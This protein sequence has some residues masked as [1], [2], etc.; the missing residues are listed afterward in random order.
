MQDAELKQNAQQGS[1][2]YQA[3]SRQHI[4]QLMVQAKDVMHRYFGY[5][6]FRSYQ[7][8]LIQKVFEGRD[9]LGVMPT[10]AGKSLVYQIP[11]AVLGGLSLVVS[12]LI[13]LMKDQVDAL[14]QAGLAAAYLN[15]SLSPAERTQVYEGA[16]RGDFHILYV[17]PERLEDPQFLDVCSRIDIPLLAVDEAHCV[18]QWGN[19]FRPS[20]R[21]IASFIGQLPKRP[22]ICALTATATAEV[23][24]DISQALGLYAPFVCVAGFDRENLYFAVERPEPSRKNACLL[25]HV[26]NRTMQSGIVYCST[27]AA[28]EE[29]S[30]LLQERGIKAAGYHAGMDTQ[31]RQKNQD[32]FIN[33]RIAIMVATNAFG[34]GI[35]KSNVN[36]VIHYNM[37]RD[38]E[39]YY[40]EAGRAGRDGSPADCILIYNKKDVQTANY[41]VDR[42]LEERREQ[43]MDELLADRLY[44]LDLDRVRKMTA[45]C[46]TS[47]CL[48]SFLL[49]YFG[50]NETPFRCEHCSTCEAAYE[51]VDATLEAQKIISCVL[52][53]DQRG[54]SV[55]RTMIVDI[56]RGSQAQKLLD[57]NFDTLSTYGI[58]KGSPKDLMHKLMDALVSEGILSIST[59]KYPIVSC[60]SKGLEFLNKREKFTF[61][62]AK[63]SSALQNSNILQARER[64]L[65]KAN[66]QK[67]RDTGQSRSFGDY[68]GE[69]DL[70]PQRKA[71]S[72][73]DEALDMQLFEKLRQLRYEKALEEELP[74]FIVFNDKSLRDMCLKLPRNEEEFLEVSGVGLAK[75]EKYAQDFLACIAEHLEHE[76]T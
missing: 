40:Q 13:S 2:A 22:R 52:R 6:S 3:Q 27:R 10:G 29:V 51:E 64:I 54:R 75:K 37:P 16:K 1:G 25:K 65:G 20:Y 74:A 31:A 26:Q 55:G 12:P 15:S 49:R 42:G 39:S 41:F 48:R 60:T 18:S 43:G 57:S 34:M 23:R 59:G 53:L 67:P 32:D 19:D 72:T 33:D 45:Y 24:D 69:E 68:A 73:Q 58:M 4:Q 8:S 30:E 21:N 7:E 50:E 56:L 46:T 70:T 35:D 11:A 36:F 9:V 66:K 28:V 5:D 44:K 62:L 76:A 61:K 38:P 14:R 47:S 63:R 71:A 17:A